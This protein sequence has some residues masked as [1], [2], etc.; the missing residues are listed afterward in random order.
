MSPKTTRILTIIA[1]I[2]LVGIL[3]N[4]YIRRG[5]PTSSVYW[6]SV[7]IEIGFGFVA[8]QLNKQYLNT[9]NHKELAILGNILLLISFIAAIVLYYLVDI[10]KPAGS[11][12]IFSLITFNTFYIYRIIKK[13]PIT[14][15]E[16]TS[17]RYLTIAKVLYWIACS[18][19]F[20]MLVVMIIFAIV[21]KIS[22][23]GKEPE[24]EVIFAIVCLPFLSLGVLFPWIIK[25]IWKSDKSNFFAYFIFAAQI[26]IIG[27]VST[28]GLVIGFVDGLFYIS[29]PLSLLSCIAMALIFPTKNRWENWKTGAIAKVNM[30]TETDLS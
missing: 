5:L 6:I 7:V 13:Q 27:T 12:W 20:I 9:H 24:L 22:V 21:G 11:T 26:S 23:I 4:G 17:G 14:Q 25:K 10:L 16:V 19:I 28:M 30:W 2:Y 15:Q 18:V 1:E 3:V 8:Y 29:L